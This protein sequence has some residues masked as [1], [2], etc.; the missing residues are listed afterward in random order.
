MVTEKIANCRA[1]LPESARRHGSARTIRGSLHWYSN[2]FLAADEDL[3]NG[4]F[5]FRTATSPNGAAFN[6][7]ERKPPGRLGNRSIQPRGGG[8]DRRRALSPRWG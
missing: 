6:S 5:H 2:E 7:Q 1:F 4:S 8:S 3:A